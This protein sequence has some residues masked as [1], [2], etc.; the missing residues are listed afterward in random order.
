VL[1]AFVQRLRNDDEVELIAFSPEAR[2]VAERRPRGRDPGW[3]LNLIDALQPDNSTNL[4][5]GL[6]LGLPHLKSDGYRDADPSRARRVVLLTD[7]IANEG[8]TDPAQ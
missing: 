7:G 4:P 5:A 1:C 8:V 2:V 3:L 6:M